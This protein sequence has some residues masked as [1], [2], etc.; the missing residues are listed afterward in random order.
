MGAYVRADAVKPGDL[1][2]LEGDAYAD[3]AGADPTYPYELA[4]VA[5][6]ELETP[7]CVAVGFEGAGVIGFPPEHLL[8]LGA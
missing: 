4:M 3:P 2:D 5:D 1:I 6:L 8:K 7:G